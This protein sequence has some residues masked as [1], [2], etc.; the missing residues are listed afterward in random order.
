MGESLSEGP[1]SLSEN[2]NQMSDEYK[3][4]TIKIWKNEMKVD[5]I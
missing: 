5:I 3:N 2:F 4:S 1:K